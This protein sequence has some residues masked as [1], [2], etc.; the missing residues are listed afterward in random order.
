MSEK[1]SQEPTTFG[2]FLRTVPFLLAILTGVYFIIEYTHKPASTGYMPIEMIGNTFDDPRY[3][4]EKDRINIMAFGAVGDGKTY[5]DEAFKAALK[6][7]ERRGLPLYF[8]PAHY[9]FHQFYF[10]ECE[11]ALFEFNGSLVELDIQRVSIP[12]DRP[13]RNLRI[14]GMQYRPR[15]KTRQ[16]HEKAVKTTHYRAVNYRGIHSDARR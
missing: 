11:G 2:H 9:L 10:P 14:T 7:V 1:E 5:D 13:I 4:I 3:Y 6:E 8:P 12:S 16:S 15:L